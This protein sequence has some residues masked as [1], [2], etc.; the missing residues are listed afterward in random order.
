VTESDEH[1][2]KY[3]IPAVQRFSHA[4]RELVAA[5][6]AGDEERLSAARDEALRAARSAAVEL[7]HQ[8]DVVWTERPS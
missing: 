3:A 1:L 7:H 6:K 8:S 2:E 4:G 5:A